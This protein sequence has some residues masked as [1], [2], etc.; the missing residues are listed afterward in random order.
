MNWENF[1]ALGSIPLVL[2]ISDYSTLRI[3]IIL[4]ISRETPAYPLLWLINISSKKHC[5]SVISQVYLVVGT[6][7]VHRYLVLTALENSFV[8]EIIRKTNDPKP[9]PIV[10]SFARY[11]ISKHTQWYTPTDHVFFWSVETHINFSSG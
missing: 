5:A 2:H 1:R 4:V 7:C 10:F 3:F 11:W 9:L 6:E 8:W